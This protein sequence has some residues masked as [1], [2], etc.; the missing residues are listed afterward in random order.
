MR[1]L[2]FVIF[3]ATIVSSTILQKLPRLVSAARV[4]RGY[5]PE[6]CQ[7]HE[8]RIAAI[9]DPLSEDSWPFKAAIKAKMNASYQSLSMFAPLYRIY[10]KITACVVLKQSIPAHLFKRLEKFMKSVR[11]NLKAIYRPVID[12]YKL[13]PCWTD[14]LDEDVQS[15]VQ[16]MVDE[17]DILIAALTALSRRHD[18]ASIRETRTCLYREL[19]CPLLSTLVKLDRQVKN[20]PLHK[21]T[22][23]D[24]LATLSTHI[25]GDERCAELRDWSYR[26]FVKQAAAEIKSLAD[27]SLMKRNRNLAALFGSIPFADQLLFDYATQAIEYPS[28]SWAYGRF[29]GDKELVQSIKTH[30]RAGE[31]SHSAFNDAINR[32]DQFVEVCLDDIFSGSAVDVAVVTERARE[33][34]NAAEVY[35]KAENDLLASRKLFVDIA[36]KYLS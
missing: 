21:N 32:W 30:T 16:R 11:K 1:C 34:S 24:A 14:E 35:I 6:T 28:I 22:P 12:V 8:S 9:V 13:L 19:L 18:I 25:A 15:N 36:L 29:P 17:V 20:R 33:I 5:I 23:N 27:T 7:L 31:Y 3:F 4:S 26:Y 10:G 2:I